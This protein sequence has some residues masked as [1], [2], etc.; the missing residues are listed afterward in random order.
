MFPMPAKEGVIIFN[1][2]V[3]SNAGNRLVIFGK[4]NPITYNSTKNKPAASYNSSVTE[5]VSSQGLYE[6]SVSYFRKFLSEE[7]KLVEEKLETDTP[8]EAYGI[9]SLLINRLT[10]RL[11]ESFVRIPRTLFLNIR[12]WVS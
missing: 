9:D 12:I 3:A 6:A 7:L 10:N 2:I 1:K 11:S 8:F 5:V 4:G